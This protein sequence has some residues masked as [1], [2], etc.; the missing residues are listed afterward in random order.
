MLLVLTRR[1][2]TVGASVGVELGAGVRVCVVVGFNAGVITGG[3]SIQNP[4]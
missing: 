4:R 2:I 3:H 1:S